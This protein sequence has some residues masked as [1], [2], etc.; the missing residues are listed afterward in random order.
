MLTKLGYPEAFLKNKTNVINKKPETWTAQKKYFFLKLQFNGD[1]V[2]E[3]LY[4]RISKAIRGTFYRGKVRLLISSRLV[5]ST[6]TKDR[7]PK[8][9]SSM[10]IYKFIYPFKE[11]CIRCTTRQLNQ[12]MNEHLSECFSKEQ[13][14]SIL[15]SILSYLVDIGHEEEKLKSF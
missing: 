11:N 4:D 10:Y 14:K 9:T 13:I 1:V 2:G 6:Q 12:R 5:L 3:I 7:L 15:S 8:F